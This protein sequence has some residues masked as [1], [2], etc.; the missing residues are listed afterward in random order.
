MLCAN[1]SNFVLFLDNSKVFKIF[2]KNLL[3]KAELYCIVY[4]SKAI[5]NKLGAQRKEASTVRTNEIGVAETEKFIHSGRF[6][7]RGCLSRYNCLKGKDE[8][9]EQG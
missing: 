5:P 2:S 3:T 9:T 8:I 6:F 1:F 7:N 4:L